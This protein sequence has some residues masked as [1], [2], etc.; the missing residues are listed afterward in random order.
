MINETDAWI[1]LICL[2]IGSFALRFSFLGWLGNR[3]LP[4][5][6]MRHLRYVAVAV[7]PGLV[8]PLVAMPAATDGQFDPP[9]AMA[10]A[11]AVLVGVVTRN[12]LASIL[13]GAAT[14]YAAL[15]WFG[16]L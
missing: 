14:L 3:P 13:G 11:V 4:G 16:A 9:R 7:M 6:V 12:V 8:A 1:V 2:T 15:W 10:A 5:W